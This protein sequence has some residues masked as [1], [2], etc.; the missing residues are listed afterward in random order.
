MSRSPTL[1]GRKCIHTGLWRREAAKDLT[2]IA[3]LFCGVAAYLACLVLSF[4]MHN[5]RASF[6]LWAW[7]A[8]LCLD[9]HERILSVFRVGRSVLPPRSRRLR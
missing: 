6:S 8:K 2:A 9:D 7:M 4:V 1:S 5:I 3:D